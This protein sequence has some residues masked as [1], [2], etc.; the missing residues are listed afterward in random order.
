MAR[1]DGQVVQQ[2]DAG[3][4]RLCK[5]QLHRVRIHRPHREPLA[6]GLERVSQVA[7][8]FPVVNRRERK[9]H[10]VGRERLS[11]GENDAVAKRQR[12]E[13]AVSRAVPAFGQP[14]LH[15]VGHLVDANEPGLRQ[16]GHQRRGVV[17]GR[18]AAEAARLDA[19]RNR[20]RATWFRSEVGCPGRGGVRALRR[21]AGSGKDGE[22]GRTGDRRRETA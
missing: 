15:F 12:V 21:S 18:E 17:A 4:E 2:A 7:A 6:V 22:K 19:R 13:A 3:R 8:G 16:F 10:I 11:V 5:P 14:R 9:H 1:Q 20:E